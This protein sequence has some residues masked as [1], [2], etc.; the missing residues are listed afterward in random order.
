[1]QTVHIQIYK[2]VDRERDREADRARARE[3][4]RDSEQ[5]D[6]SLHATNTQKGETVDT[7]I[8]EYK[9]QHIEAQT[10]TNTT[11]T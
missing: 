2:Y 7:S 11:Q 6:M 8:P 1:M 10:H 5:I 9:V 3:R 4:E